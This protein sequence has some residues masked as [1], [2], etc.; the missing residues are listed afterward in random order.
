VKVKDEGSFYLTKLNQSS[1]YISPRLEFKGTNLQPVSFSGSIYKAEGG[2]VFKQTME[3]VKSTTLS[4]NQAVYKVTWTLSTKQNNVKQVIVTTKSKL[5]ETSWGQL[6][7]QTNDDPKH[8][9]YNPET[10]TVTW[11]PG[12]IDGY[13]GLNENPVLTISFNIFVEVTPGQK[14]NNISLFEDV[15][16]QGTDDYTGVVYTLK[17]EGVKS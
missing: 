6:K 7:I 3:E 15:G 16:I 14:L 5:P 11:N 8:F 2:L 12:D 4:A 9:N 10:G 13:L 17:E 1:Y